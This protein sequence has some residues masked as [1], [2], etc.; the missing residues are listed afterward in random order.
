MLTLLHVPFISKGHVSTAE[1][2]KIG[3]VKDS[4]V[5]DP[6]ISSGTKN[7]MPTLP[8]KPRKKY[9]EDYENFVVE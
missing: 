7:A 5:E 6:F 3:S 1:S 8:G 4:A 2:S 9:L